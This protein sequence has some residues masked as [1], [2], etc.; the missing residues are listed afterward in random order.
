MVARHKEEIFVCTG[1]LEDWT[2][3]SWYC[4]NCK[5]EVAELKQGCIKSDSRSLDRRH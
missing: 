5:N 3:Y 1:T 2:I 4:P